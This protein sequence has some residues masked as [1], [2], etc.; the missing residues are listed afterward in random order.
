MGI[1]SAAPLLLLVLQQGAQ[2]YGA[3][4]AVTPPLFLGE[5]WAFDFFRSVD[6][7]LSYVEPWFADEDYV[8]FDVAGTPLRLTAVRPPRRRFRPWRGAESLRIEPAGAPDP[9]A[10]AAVLRQFLAASGVADVSERAP[11]QDLIDRAVAHAGWT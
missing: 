9:D 1:S 7:A 6:D 8:A 4:V 2:R 5:R 10:A 11:L 3:R